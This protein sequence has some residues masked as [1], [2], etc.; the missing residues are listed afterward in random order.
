MVPE[1]DEFV[2]H[3]AGFKNSK[4]TC[5]GIRKEGKENMEEINM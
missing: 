4:Q 1:S 5:S 3:T 2:I